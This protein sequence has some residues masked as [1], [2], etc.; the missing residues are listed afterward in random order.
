VTFYTYFWLRE[1]GTPYYVGKGTGIRAYYTRSHHVCCP[2]RKRI[3]VQEHLT[4]ADALV[5]EKFF[6]SLF[7]RIDI[8]TGCLRN[9]TDGGENPPNWKGKKRSEH[10]SL[11]L[12]KARA[13]VKQPNISRA[14]MGNQCGRFTKGIKKGPH[15]SEWKESVRLKMIAWWKERKR[16][17]IKMIYNYSETERKRRSEQTLAMWKRGPAA[18]GR[19]Q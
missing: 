6:I 5:A 7:G 9:L 16:L 1:N 15:S 19:Q 11:A 18:F 2:D 13:G 10:H 12:S 4:E 8:G 14:K 3:V 17:G